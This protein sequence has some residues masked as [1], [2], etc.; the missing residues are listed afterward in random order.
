LGFANIN[1]EI[2]VLW[3]VGPIEHHPRQFCRPVGPWKDSVFS[4]ALIPS[5]HPL[6]TREHWPGET[7]IKSESPSKN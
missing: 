4:P 3:K 1:K 7:T 6:I 2:K 5:F